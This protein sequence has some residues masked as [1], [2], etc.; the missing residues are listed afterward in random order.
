M[1]G[2]NSHRGNQSIQPCGAATPVPTLAS[3]PSTP[4]AAT[5]KPAP[6]PW[7]SSSPPPNSIRI[8]LEFTKPFKTVNPTTFT[9]TPAGNG[10]Q[11]TWTMTGENKGLGKIFALFMNMDKMV[12]VDFDKG[13]ASL[14]AAA[15]RR[16]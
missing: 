5:A 8:R 6:E 12:G 11:V 3:V 9:F 15:Q 10:T 7:K 14:A 4:G 2:P 1:S 13:L 16:S